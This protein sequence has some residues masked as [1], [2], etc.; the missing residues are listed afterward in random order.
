[1]A[2]DTAY[3]FGPQIEEGSQLTPLAAG[4]RTKQDNTLGSA[5]NFRKGLDYLTLNPNSAYTIGIGDFT[6]SL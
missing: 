4:L 5:L 2:Q 6:I 3:K 1:M